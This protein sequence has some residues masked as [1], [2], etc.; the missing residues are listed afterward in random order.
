MNIAFALVAG[1]HSG[2]RMLWDA[3]RDGGFLSETSWLEF[4]S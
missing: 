2:T 4:F 3:H 1:K